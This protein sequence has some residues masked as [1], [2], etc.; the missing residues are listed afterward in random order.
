MAFKNFIAAVTADRQAARD[1]KRSTA[2]LIADA[3]RNGV[4]CGRSIHHLSIFAR[5]CAEYRTRQKFSTFS[6]RGATRGSRHES[7][8]SENAPPG[9]TAATRARIKL[10]FNGDS[11]FARLHR[12]RAAPRRGSP[13]VRVAMPDEPTGTQRRRR[14]R[15]RKKSGMRR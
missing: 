8:P 3:S 13:V 4:S 7:A 5:K 15:R 11:N 9:A 12:G 10:R 14:R 2:L 6:R 1:R